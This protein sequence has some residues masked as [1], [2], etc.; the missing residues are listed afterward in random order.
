[1]R[2]KKGQSII[3]FALLVAIVIIAVVLGA[4]V[5]KNTFNN[6]FHTASN[7]YFVANPSGAPA[8]E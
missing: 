7:G 5:G 2:V 3:E 4:G 1:M 6:Q 8:S